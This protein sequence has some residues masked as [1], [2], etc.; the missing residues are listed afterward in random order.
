MLTSRKNAAVA[1]LALVTTDACTNILVT[2]SASADTH[3]MIAYNADD[4]ALHGGVARWAAAD[5]SAGE[6]REIFSWDLGW[7]LGEIP[8]PA[9][10]YNVIGNANEMGLV[11]GET[12]LG[13]L[14]ELSNVGKDWRNGTILDYGSLIWV[15]LQRAA[16]ARE[17]IQVIHELTDKYGYAS[18]MEGF[19]ISDPS[20]EVW[21]MELIG[22]GGFEK[23]IVYVAQRVPDGYVHTHANQ[24]RIR[25]FLPCDDANTCLM[26]P[27]VVSFAIK[28]GYWKGA[29]D[30]PAFSFSDIYDPVTF[31][32]ARFCEARVWAIFAAIADKESFD[33]DAYLDYARGENLTNRMPLFVKPK[34]ALTREAVHALM[35]H[36]YQGSYFDPA[37]DVGA[38]AEHS[39][40]R[41]NGLSWEVG[42]TSYVNERIVGTQS[43][44]WHF[45]ASLRAGVPKAMGALLYWGADDHSWAPK[46]PIHGGASAVH[47]SYDD[48]NCTGRD[49]CRVE[50]G[51][52]GTV[53]NFSWNS[54]WW[55]NQAVADQ[56]Y[57]RMDRAAPVVLAARKELDA[58]LDTALKAA[59]TDATAK[60]AAGDVAGAHAVLSAH[61]VQAGA[62]ALAA[63][64]A[65]WQRLT[66]LF[67]DG[68]TTKINPKNE[69]CGCDKPSVEFEDAWKTKVVADDGEHYK[70][71][72]QAPYQARL[73]AGRHHTK[74][75]RDKL[76][77]RGVAP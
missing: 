52:E 64:T 25:T 36:H 18:D 6:M 20:G 65:L 33:P 37:K 38:G 13:G 28:R 15:T 10:T 45:V 12:T 46:I 77:I 32:G 7:K 55:V 74:P 53:T 70:V 21:Y 9:H 60:F 23:G 59:E 62:T 5:H 14:S 11:I 3:A 47:S 22:K 1:L 24:A 63:W 8:E 71:P 2:P 50:M 35:S 72:N 73:G 42:G 54:A 19:S 26:A 30:D 43:T 67:V 56:V 66:M 58:T 57:T 17:A 39:P 49:P 68:K 27:D 76:S 4:S 48:S 34:Q 75:T 44:S 51:L 16:T 40:Y 41:W 31:S 29:A 61:S 69:V